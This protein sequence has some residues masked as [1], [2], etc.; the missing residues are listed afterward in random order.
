MDSLI[1][2]FGTCRLQRFPV[3]KN[4][5]LRAWNAADELL[6]KHVY[7]LGLHDYRTKFL[8]VNDQFGALATSLHPFP[9]YCWSDSWLSHFSTRQNLASNKLNPDITYVPGNVTLPTQFD[10][11][12]IKIPKTLALLEDQLIRLTRHISPDTILIAAGMVKH[13][14]TSTLN[15]FSTILGPT[16]TSLASKKARL[17]FSTFER[18]QQAAT[19]PYPKSH[20]VKIH[21]KQTFQ[22]ILTHHANVFAKEKLDLGSR[23][24]LE[25]FDQLPPAK[26]I[27]DLGCGDGVLGIVAQ[28]LMPD[29]KLTFVDESYMSIASSRTNYQT[30]CPENKQVQFIVGDCLTQIDDKDI[31]FIL[32]NP[33][34]HQEHTISD[35]I[36]WRMFSQSTRRLQ[37]GGKIWVVGNRHLAYHVKLKR[38]FGNCKTIA[39]NRKFVVLQSVRQ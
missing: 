26:H 33:P 5:T 8:L 25:Q 28:R 18:P 29:S 35:H 4:E 23:F 21:V 16:K 11:V 22:L 39:A 36:A 7:E 20:V 19:P 12:L 27:V 34:F 13:I 6:L 3:R 15:L 2:P 14:H 37:Q 30:N 24:M 31:D 38:L 10:I 1:T 9:L 32:C 17:I